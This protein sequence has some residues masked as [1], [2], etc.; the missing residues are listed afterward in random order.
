MDSGSRP[1][2]SCRKALWRHSSSRYQTYF[3][4]SSKLEFIPMS[5][6]GGEYSWCCSLFFA[7]MECHASSIIFAFV[8]VRQ[9]LSRDDV[10]REICNSWKSDRLI[11]SVILSETIGEMIS[12]ITGWSSVR[13]A[14][15]DIIWKPPSQPRTTIGFHQDSTYISD[16]FIPRE[17]N[18]VTV[19]MALDDV[20]EDM[21]CLE[22]AVGSHRC[23]N[24]VS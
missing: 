4:A 12:R 8:L 15:D 24:R 5:G 1:P 13:I 23:P 14:Q 7:T 17:N 3:G 19:W 22:Y 10:T 11:A 6:I 16:Q 18:S 20:T 2:V 9:G 21:G